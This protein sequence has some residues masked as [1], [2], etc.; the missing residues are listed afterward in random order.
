MRWTGYLVPTDHRRINEFVG[1]LLLT[2]AILAGLSLISFNPDDPSFNISKNPHFDSR[3]TNFVGFVGAYG[4]DVGFQL[5]GYSAFLIP[6]FVGI[7]A[8]CWLASWPMRNF[9]IRISGMILMVFTLSAAFSI[10]PSFP[11]VR[12]HVPAGGLVGTLLADT[13]ETSFNP[14]GSVIVLIAA[15]LVSLFLATKFSFAWAG[16]ILKPRLRFVSRLSERWAAR[17]AAKEAEPKKE[18]PIQKQTI[19]TE[20]PKPVLPVEKT[21]EEL[22]VAASTTRPAPRPKANP[23]A[24]STEFPPT[25]LLHAPAAG[26]VVGRH[27]VSGSQ[28]YGVVAVDGVLSWRRDHARRARIQFPGGRIARRA[29]SAPAQLV[30]TPGR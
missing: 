7:Y 10:A 24:S 25:T 23:A 6:V 26:A 13:L 5:W 18:K 27:A 4:A 22:V 1:L 19:V 9:G 12:G 11:L 29:R 30:A 16:E 17:K 8:F 21:K 14:A 15:F 2:V 3:P 28:L 20:K